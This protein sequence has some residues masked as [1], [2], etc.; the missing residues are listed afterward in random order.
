[1]E[2]TCEG[3]FR[4]RKLAWCTGSQLLSVRMVWKL[5]PKRLFQG[6]SMQL[7]LQRTLTYV[8]CSACI[9][10]LASAALAISSA[11]AWEV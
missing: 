1:M 8:Q 9:S 3:H 6:H 5:W 4:Q 10:M 11:I 7:Q 2:N